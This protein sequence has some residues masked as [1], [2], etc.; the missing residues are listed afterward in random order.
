MRLEQSAMLL[1]GKLVARDLR[2]VRQQTTKQGFRPEVVF[3]SG[4]SLRTL[5]LA[6]GAAIAYG[7]PIIMLNMDDWMTAESSCRWP[8]QSVW[9][10]YISKVMRD[11][12][13]HVQYAY[14]NSQQL[15][16]VLTERYGIA[17]ETM[18]NACADLVVGNRGW[19]PPPKRHGFVLTYAGAMNWKLQ[20]RT[21]VR[22]AEAVS[23]LD[24]SNHVELRLFTP[25]EFA[26]LANSIQVPGKVTYRGFV[27]P[28][29]LVNEYLD[30]D[31]LL[32]TT[33]FIDKELHLFR[34]SLAT[35]LSDYLCVGR[36]VL[37]I[38][39][40]Q[41]ALHSYVEENQ[42]GWAIRSPDRSDIKRA[43]LSALE[44]PSDGRE[45]MGRRNRELWA[46]AHDVR[47]MAKRVRE[48]VGLGDYPEGP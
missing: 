16:Q 18:N 21:L 8:I 38:G 20:G 40:P 14:S 44:T 13:P 25:W 27:S 26:P 10:R 48:L 19:A 22:V 9:Q 34:H 7:V 41:W 3:F 33:T 5:G 6:A 30:S 37:S 2:Y 32:A 23:E 43:I 11:A 15:A 35:K 42:C 12:A 46:R 39:H 45:A 24:L 47:V 1:S 36:P 31:F 28:S 17:H 4:L 29:D